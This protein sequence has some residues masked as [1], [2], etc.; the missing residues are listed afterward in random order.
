M[1]NFG[2]RNLGLRRGNSRD[3]SP[4]GPFSGDLSRSKKNPDRGSGFLRG[5]AAG[6]SRRATVSAAGAASAIKGGRRSPQ[7]AAPIGAGRRRK[8]GNAEKP[9]APKSRK[10]RTA[11][12]RR[13]AASNGRRRRMAGRNRMTG[14]AGPRVTT[15][16]WPQQ[17]GGPCRTAGRGRKAGSAGQQAARGRQAAPDVG[18]RRM[19]GGAGWLAAPDGWRRRM[20]GGG[21]ATGSR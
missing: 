14:R 9:A 13:P 4:Q 11:G 17:G 10:C 8:A 2:C 21:R 16:S 7:P 12:R 20:A 19:A 6:R 5:F 1:A 3:L 18:P 15:E